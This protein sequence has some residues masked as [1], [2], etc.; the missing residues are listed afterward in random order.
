MHSIVIQNVYMS[1]CD[2][3]EKTMLLLYE[4]K[5][6]CNKLLKKVK[7]KKY[8][9]WGK[10]KQDLLISQFYINKHSNSKLTLQIIFSLSWQLLPSINH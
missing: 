7:L 9:K 10:L 8:S 2:H 5:V 4:A 1:Q 6:I 3:L